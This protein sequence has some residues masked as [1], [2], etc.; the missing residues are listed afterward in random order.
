MK[1]DVNLDANDLLLNVCALSLERSRAAWIL[2]PA[3][4]LSCT[5]QSL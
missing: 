3:R 2:Q 1:I 4:V 5:A